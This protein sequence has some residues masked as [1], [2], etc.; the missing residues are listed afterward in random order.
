MAATTPPKPPAVTYTPDGHA[1]APGY[2]N[3]GNPYDTGYHGQQNRE[4]NG[5]RGGKLAGWDYDHARPMDPNAGLG[6]DGL[7]NN[8]GGS[9]GGGGG[10]VIP[11]AGT[12]LA[13][14]AAAEKAYQDAI[15]QLMSTRRSEQFLTG[16][17]DAPV[18]K[19]VMP[20][21]LTHGQQTKWKAAHQYDPT[22]GGAWS[23]DPN[24]TVGQ[25]QQLLGQ[26]GSDLDANIANNQAHGFF[27][28]G[29]G[30]QGER[31]L[32]FQQ[33][34]QNFGFQNQIGKYESDYQKG[35]QDALAARQAA[36]L[37]AL[38]AA[39]AAAYGSGDWTDYGGGGDTGYDPNAGQAPTTAGTTPVHTPSAADRNAGAG[40][41]MSGFGQPAVGRRAP[42]PRPVGYGFGQAGFARRAAT[43][44]PRR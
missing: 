22:V 14:Q 30:N 9:G 38:Q 42:A 2:Y 29:L 5:G 39:Q 31:A 7:Y 11:G 35:R 40:N 6:A 23:V 20:T 15:T 24:S 43:P 16:F 10:S 44:P 12:Y 18:Q 19:A 27:G 26:E 36:M 13:D 28:A 33:A 17:Y 21:G 25:Y 41:P 34:S 32:R 1:R 4:S 8:L 37:A 3:P